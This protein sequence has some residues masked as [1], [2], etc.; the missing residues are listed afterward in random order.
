MTA[1][2]YFNLEEVLKAG[3]AVTEKTRKELAIKKQRLLQ[4][5][6]LVSEIEEDGQWGYLLWNL[7]G[8]EVL[9]PDFPEPR[10][11]NLLCLDTDEPEPGEGEMYVAVYRDSDGFLSSS[12]VIYDTT[13]GA[14]NHT[15][16][17]EKIGIYKLT[18]V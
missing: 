13:L 10:H 18:K 6:C 15:H 12:Y 2:T 17:K 8:T 7:D 16:G 14:E 4:Y 3:R 11:G 5:D 1:K 9:N